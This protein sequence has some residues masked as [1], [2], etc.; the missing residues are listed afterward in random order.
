MKFSKIFKFILLLI[1]LVLLLF[2]REIIVNSVVSTNLE[3][4]QG[5]LFVLTFIFWLEILFLL[6]I[7]DLVILE[8]YGGI[9]YYLSKLG[10]LAVRTKKVSIALYTIRLNYYLLRLCQ[11]LRVGWVTYGSGGKSSVWIGLSKLSLT[12]LLLNIFRIIIS[13]PMFLAFLFACFSLNI[14]RGDVAYYLHKLQEFLR[15]F[16]QIKVNIGDIFS[17]LPALVALITIVPVIFFFYFYS[18]KRDVRKIIDKENSQYFEEVVLLYEQLLIW[19][20]RHIY[21]ISENFDYVINC[22]DSIVETFL[23]KE[24]SNYTSLAGKQYYIH[25]GVERFRFVEIADLTK[26]R[27]I[28]TELSSDRLMKFTR[29]FSTKRFDIWYLYFWDFHSLDEE[30]KIEKSFY[31]KKGM[32]S[33][34]DNRHTHSYDFTQEQIDKRRKEEF[35]LLSWSIYDNLELLYRFKRASDSLRKYLYSSRTERLI[36]KAL[37][38]DK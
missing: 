12:Q 2:L 36:L 11:L 34:L 15:V 19:L 33:K 28:I 24:V 26:L 23:K 10:R 7:Y 32:T 27:K 18:Q 6:M 37:N 16:L 31:T 21:E 13:A 8:L 25:G 9:S 3:V 20:D 4:S 5:N 29:I 1:V 14:L 17:R 30:E 35:S 38:K 22:Q